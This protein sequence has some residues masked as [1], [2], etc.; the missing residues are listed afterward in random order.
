MFIKLSDVYRA[1][2]F[3]YNA[4]YEDGR[5]FYENDWYQRGNNV[6]ID[7]KEDSPVQ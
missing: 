2:K 1:E 7:N 6:I 5:L 4:R 3:P